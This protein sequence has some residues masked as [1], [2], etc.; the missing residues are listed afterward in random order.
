MN[1]LLTNDDG[2]TGEGLIALANALNKEHKVTIV[3]PKHNFSGASHLISLEKTLKLNKEFEKDVHI[4]YSLT[5]SPADC[6]KFGIKHLKL[7]PDLIISGVNKGSNLGTETFYSGTVSASIE[8]AILGYKSIAVSSAGHKDNDFKFCADYIANNIN[9]FY[10]L[11]DSVFALNINIPN[12]PKNQIQ[13]LKFTSF[14]VQEYSDHYETFENDEFMLQGDI[15]DFKN[16]EDCDV[17]WNK[18]G[19]ITAT[20]ML[21]DRTDYNAL[22]RLK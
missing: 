11:F 5:G 7:N 1:I 18:K 22:N 20:P 13:G 6:V 8:G 16:D 4:Y 9:Y 2:I 3:A 19:Y 21:L 17:E 12:I 14:G 15:I 10:N